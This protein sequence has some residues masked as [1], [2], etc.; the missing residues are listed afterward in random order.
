MQTGRVEE[1]L[2]EWNGLGA[3]IGVALLGERDV[4]VKAGV[5]GTGNGGGSMGLEIDEC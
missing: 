5:V 4:C 3:G 1:C 2:H